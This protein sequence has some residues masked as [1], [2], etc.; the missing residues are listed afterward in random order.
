MKVLVIGCG[1][2]GERAADLLHEAGHEVTG[3]THSEISASR[4]AAAKPYAVRDCDVSDVSSVHAL[5]M[6]PEI[7]I[8][9]ASS[10]RGGAEMYQKV[11]L[12]GSR[13]LVATFP[14]AGLIFCSSTSVYPQIDGGW[15][16][17]ES[18]ATPARETSRILRE[19]E[20]FILSRNGC[21]ARLA[22]IYGPGRSFVLKNFLEDTATIEGNNDQGRWLNQIHRE[23]AARALVHLATG[24][25]RGIFNVADNTPLTQRACFE[26]LAARFGKVMP[27]V[28]E[29]NTARKRAWTS[30]QVS[31]AKLRAT[32]WTPIFEDYFA[33][34]EKDSALVPSIMTQVAKSNADQAKSMNIVLIGLMGSGKSAVGRLAAQSLGFE[35]VDTDQM[36]VS[37][38]GKTIPEIFAS[39]GE[40]GFRARETA[41]L[42][43]L[44]GRQRHVIATGGGIVTQPDNLPLLQQLGFVVWLNADIEILRR[45]TSRSHDRPL[46]RTADPAA[47]LRELF[48]ARA[49]LYESASELK[50]TTDDLSLEDA[51]Y[52][53]AESA[54][55]H[56]NLRV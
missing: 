42:R 38:A 14:D 16:T 26:A 34:L 31:N 35:F 24:G 49:P 25:L 15:V 33:A 6:K 19:T 27:P 43:S 30:K 1:Y 47:V 9:C 36:I 50:I 20:N 4:L 56:F 2:V 28:V 8:H 29:P 40:A 10:N 18:D 3:V 39:E 21:I 51:A 45:R 37:S 12:D 52:G 11:Y 54:R 7:V 17:E 46:L 41:I 44:I 53:L 13:N 5:E 22:G 32:G 23:D 55:V 48:A